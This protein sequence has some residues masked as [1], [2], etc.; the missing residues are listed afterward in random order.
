MAATLVNG[1]AYDYVNIVFSILGV[2]LPSITAI[3]YVEE[4][5]KVNNMGASNRP[6]SRGHGAIDS[7]GSIE[8]SMNDIEALRDVAPDGSLLKIPAFDIVVTY[9]NPENIVRNHVLRFVEFKNDGS[10]ASSGDTD[11]KKTLDLVIGDVKYR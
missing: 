11:I 7:N 9:L 6:V 5:D 10:E 2:S 3:N 4:Q 1:K 8:L